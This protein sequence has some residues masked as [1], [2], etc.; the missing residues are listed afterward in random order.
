MR[1]LPFKPDDEA[2]N[3]RWELVGISD[4]PPGP[5]AQRSQPRF[6]VPI[7]D[8]VSGLARYTKIS[9][10]VTHC[11][12]VEHAGNEP[13]ALFH[14]RTLSP[15]HRH[16]PPQKSGKVLPMCPVRT[17]THVSGRSQ[18]CWF[19]TPKDCRSPSIPTFS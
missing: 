14:H 15:R 9:T 5:I 19:V 6:L 3:L 7:V 10:D 8:F 4:R 12:T 2:L 13:K 11:L 16:L 17:V 1:F 18:R